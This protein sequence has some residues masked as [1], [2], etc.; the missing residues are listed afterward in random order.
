MLKPIVALIAALVTKSPD[1]P[2]KRL[3]A[4]NHDPALAG[5]DLLVRVEGEDA[6]VSHGTNSMAAV[7]CT[8]G[9]TGILNHQQAMS[10][11]DSENGRHL[12]RNP[13]RM[14]RKNSPRPVRDRLFDP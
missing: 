14:N 7:L 12:C 8:D 9:L 3:I 2:G 5:S 11:G 1:A 4:R 10:F 13:E 6:G